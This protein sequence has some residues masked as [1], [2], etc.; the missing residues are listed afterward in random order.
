MHDLA[1]IS[2]T[3]ILPASASKVFSCLAIVFVSVSQILSL[4][5]GAP[6]SLEE[7]HKAGWREAD[8]AGAGM[9]DLSGGELEILMGEQ[10]SGVT[11]KNELPAHMNYEVS[12]E[13]MKTDGN[14][15][16]CGLTFP[17]NDSACSLILGGWGGGVMGISSIDGQDASSNETTDYMKFEKDRWYQ[18]LVRVTPGRIQAFLDG[19]SIADVNTA[20]KKIDVRFGVEDFMPLG[21]GTYQTSARFRNLTWRDI[22]VPGEADLKSG[23]GFISS[24]SHCEEEDL[25][26]L[27][28]YDGLRV[29]D[30][31]DALDRF[32]AGGAMVMESSIHA[33]WKDTAKFTHRIA[34]IAVTARYMP[35]Q[36]GIPSFASDDAFNQWVGETYKNKT[37]EAFV[38]L[39]NK[40]TIVVIEEAGDRDTGSIGSNNILSWTLKGARGVIT[41]NT[42]R[43]L[44]EIA[45]QKIP[46]YFKKPGRGIRP[47]RNQL[48]SVN[49]PVVCGG[50]Q[51][52]PGDVIVADGD[53]VVVVP[54]R[55]ALQVA[56]FAHSVL[57]QDKAG[58]K[59][60]YKKLGL[61]SDPS[62]E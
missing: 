30:V 5:A 32:G 56:E 43:D 28:Q 33:L 46:L 14:D 17:Y 59:D 4:G 45:A 3:R 9:V 18:V 42:A 51:V 8:Y 15:F 35:S 1:M 25:K 27:A 48:E 29:A 23:H 49:R 21:I 24:S 58:R 2:G 36:Q 10:L 16:F 55:L 37:P 44:D 53:G 61:P 19:R 34:G 20:N 57:K 13:A 6:P 40:G 54:R 31:N 38:P 47:G 7:C 52:R 41:S 12:V 39:I 22:A 62:I 50:V 26:I 11:W 60:S